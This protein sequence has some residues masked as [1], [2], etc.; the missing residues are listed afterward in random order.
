MTLGE[1]KRKVWLLLDEYSSGGVPVRD[2]DI[3]AKMNDFFDIAQQDMAQWRPILRRAA[4]T[5]DGTGNQA[6]PPD[7]A[8]VLRIA[9]EGARETEALDGRLLYPAGGRAALTLEYVA[10]PAK[11]TPET[12]DDYVF[13]VGEE[14]AQCL[15]FFVAAQQLIADLTVDHRAFYELY[16]QMKRQLD[17]TAGLGVRAGA[18]RMRQG[19]YGGD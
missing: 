2:A 17:R 3:E 4:V 1:G 7:V 8:R 11:I 14:A 15:P 18:A 16:L 9:G 6:L 19:L 13:E 12:G 10:L 5:Q